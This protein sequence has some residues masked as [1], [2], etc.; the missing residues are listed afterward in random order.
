MFY[1]PIVDSESGKIIKAE[2]LL[3]WESQELGMISPDYFIPIAEDTGLILPIGD[4]V[5]NTACKQVKAWRESGWENFCVTINV[6]ARQFQS[7][8]SLVDT[9]SKALDDNNLPPAAIQIE[10]TEG[11]L[12]EETSD[13][14]ERMK[15]IESMGI[16]LLIDD[17]GTGYASLS[18]LQRYNF[19]SIKIDRSYING[20]LTNEQDAK[21]V[22]AVI[23]MANSLGMSVVSEGVENKEQLDFLHNAN[24][25][26]IQGY[27][28]SKPVKPEELVVL[29]KKF[30]GLKSNDKSL[31]RVSNVA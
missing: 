21:L 7:D 5:V 22:K 15:K 16:K 19:E 30:N 10:L 6:S 29:L 3:R 12:L 25:K 9:V 24:C 8:S 26:F 13:S 17:F 23:A 18:Y 1:Q 4:W 31:K 20:V 28:F 2:A 11:V 14:A 27:Y